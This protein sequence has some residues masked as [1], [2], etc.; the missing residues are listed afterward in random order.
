MSARVRKHLPLL[1]WMSQ[2]KPQTVKSV[3]KGVDKEVLDVLCECCLNVLKGNVPLSPAQKR[4]L[5]KQKTV[6]RQLSGPRRLSLKTQRRLVQTGGFLG[7]LP[8]LLRLVVPL[9]GA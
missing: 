2:C 6:L 8:T 7:V 5:K 3:L 9:L 1:K 4:R